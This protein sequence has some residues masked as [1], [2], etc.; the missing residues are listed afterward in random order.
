MSSRRPATAGVDGYGRFIKVDGIRC[1]RARRR[2]QL[3]VTKAGEH[4]SVHLEIFA[5]SHASPVFYSASSAWV[6]PAELAAAVKRIVGFWRADRRRSP[7]SEPAFR[8][9]AEVSRG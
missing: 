7:W 6:K 2:F 1:Q 9:A 8:Q 4:V 5:A 3:I